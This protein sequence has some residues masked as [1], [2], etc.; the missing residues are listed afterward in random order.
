[1]RTPSQCLRMGLMI[2]AHLPPSVLQVPASVKQYTVAPLDSASIL[3]VVEGDATATSAAALSDVTLSRGTVLFI[4]AN[5]G[6][7]LHIS[8]KSGMDM[9]RACCLL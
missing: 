5:E 6:V 7:A 9:F 1:M 3:L 2:I 8:S 4:S